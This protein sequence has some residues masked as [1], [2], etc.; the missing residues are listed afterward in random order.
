MRAVVLTL[1]LAFVVPH[2]AAHQTY[3]YKYEALLLGGLPEQGLA[4]AGLK[5]SSK[6]HITAEANNQ[7]MLKLVEPELFEYSG[8]WPKGSFTSAVKLTSAL[9]PQLTVPIKFEYTN[10][11]VG[12][13]LVPEGVSVMVAN[14]YKGILNVL[15]LN[16]KETQNTYEMQ[17]AGVQ[18]MCK[19]LY[20]ITEHEEAGLMHLIKVRDM[21]HCQEK[22]IKDLGLAYTEKCE[23]CQQ[24]Y[25]N[26]NGATTYSYTLKLES[27]GLLIKN[28][29]VR[30]L[31]QFA[32]FNQMKGSAQMET[33]QY[34][35]L[36]DVQQSRVA[37]IQ[38]HYVPHESLKYEFS[39]ELLQTPIQ[40]FKIDNVHSQI[41]KTLDHLISHNMERVHEDAPLKFLELV[42]LVRAARYEDLKI[43]WGQLR[44]TRARQW[45]LDAVPVIG[46]EVTFKFIREEIKADTITLPEAAQA[47]I[48]SI[49]MVTANHEVVRELKLIR[50]EKIL[51]NPALREI[52][53]LGYGTMLH[54][55]S[56]E[57]AAYPEDFVRPIIEGLKEAVDSDRTEDIILL[58]KVLGN[59]GY[60]TTLKPIT[61]FLPIHGTVGAKMPFRVN[62]EAIMA[63][64][65]IAKK[66]H[67]MV[68]SLAVQLYMDKTLHPELRMLAC[69]VLFETKP[70]MGLV[71]SLATS[72]K[73]EKNLQVASFTYS[74]MKSLTRSISPMHASLAAA[75]DVAIKILSHQKDRLS[76]RYS[77]AMHIDTFN[78]PFMVGAAASA[79]Y[80]NDAATIMPR[81]IVAKTTAY[82]TG[83]AADVLEV[84]V[85]AEGIQEALAKHP[86]LLENTDRMTKMKRAI[87][88]NSKPLASIYIKFFGQEIAFANFD[89]AV[90]EQAILA[91]GP[92]L[93]QLGRA[94]LSQAPYHLTKSLLISEMRRII[95]TTAGFPMELSQYT[96]A[97]AAA[98]VKVKVHSEPQ[99]PENFQLADLLNTNVE[100]ETEIQPSVAV[101]TFAVMGVNTEKLQAALLLRAKLSSVV[102]AHIK[103]NLN[104]LEY[105]FKIQA[106][107]VSVPEKLADLVETFAVSRN[108]EDFS[109]K[110]TQI[111]PAESKSSEILTPGDN[112]VKM[113]TKVPEI[114]KKYCKS[115]VGLMGCLRV[116]SQNAAFLKSNSSFLPSFIILIKNNA[117]MVLVEKIAESLEIELQLGSKAAEKLMKR[118][119]LSEEDLSEARPILNKL[120]KLLVPQN[121]NSSSSSSSS[122]SQSNSTSSSSSSRSSARIVN[123]NIFYANTLV[124]HNHRE[125]SVNIFVLCN[126]FLGSKLAP[127]LALILRVVRADKQMQG[128]QVALYLDKD[129]ARLQFI[130][131]SLAADSNWRLCADGVV[132][133]KNK[134]T[135]EITW[136]D[137]CKQYGLRF[138]AE[139][140][141]VKSSPAARLRVSWERVPS[142]LKE[143]K[144]FPNM[145]AVLTHGKDKV[146]QI[147]VAVVARSQRALDFIWKT[148]TIIQCQFRD[149]SL[150]TFNNKTY[151]AEIPFYCY[152]ILAQDCTDERKFMVLH[153]KDEA[154]ERHI[155]VKILDIDIDFYKS[156]NRMAVKIN[157]KE[158]Q[159]PYTHSSGTVTIRQNGEEISVFA[160]RNGLQEVSVSPRSWRIEVVDWMKGKTCGICG[161]ADGEVRQE[162]RTPSGRLASNAV[163]YAHSWTLPAESCKDT[164]ECQLKLESVQLEKQMN[165]R[166][167]ENQCF[168]VEPV[169]RC[170]PGCMPVKTTT[171]TVGFHCV[172]LGD[173]F[174][175]NSVDVTE[176]AQAHL[177]C[178]CSTQCS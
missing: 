125:S 33:K 63:L 26:L 132:L 28:A 160:P 44:M 98:N 139:T 162:F 91:T 175:H 159:L 24:H 10:G 75:C 101:N 148:V 43:L 113:T 76:S 146:R 71:L 153:R 117:F 170:L 155:N 121:R 47:L 61:K 22:I 161:W 82:F 164:T 72:V 67:K 130:L 40:L 56:I 106:L 51:N 77:R 12:R 30:E 60:H 128:Y 135:T 45:I 29:T 69:I 174:Y 119:N 99:L 151:T 149:E 49:H 122:S 93:R 156:G 20:T 81:S 110:I 165:I 65:N 157:G 123:V 116:E 35:V 166:G 158:I 145:R 86:E 66:E 54:K 144:N 70:H 5:L 96:A 32:P 2:F 129:N 105:N 142:A 172:R 1:L 31:I 34:L 68:Q 109:E 94:L 42:Q 137:K 79:F 50:E 59:A 118:I 167:E 171:V 163:S 9:R 88:P 115:A 73:T 134:T 17:E 100:L 150:T 138:S 173:S 90:I 74:H 154:G 11:V 143:I 55:Y 37:P 83:V 104:F 6:V 131:A 19:T 136:G 92:Q 95:P 15:Q 112:R 48:A 114:K 18:G 3:V 57:M 124:F 108:I 8:V 46:T 16:I 141:V 23:K 41:M 36:L 85:R 25:K 178:S 147:S 80:I 38:A 7:Y 169:L 111:V 103:A 126:K 58:L 176:A 177:A 27:D 21:N 62:A 64:R 4:R 89:K 52:V 39:T 152:Q 102:P 127:A 133:S 107:P 120:R 140:G 13:V 84:G 97:V 87:K 14:I 53:F 78:Y 168:S